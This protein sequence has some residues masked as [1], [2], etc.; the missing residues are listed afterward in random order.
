MGTVTARVAIRARRAI[1][2]ASTRSPVVASFK[3][4]LN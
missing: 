3:Y 1:D 2:I 4:V